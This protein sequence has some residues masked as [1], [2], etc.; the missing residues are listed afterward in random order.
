VICGLSGGV[1]SSVA[2][3]LDPEAIGDQLTCIFVDTGLMRAGEAER[4]VSLFRNHYNIPLIHADAREMFLGR[5]KGVSDPEQKRKISAPPSSM[6]STRKAQDRRRG[7]PRPRHPLS[8]RDRKRFGQR[9]TF[10]HH[11]EPPQ[12]RRL[13]DF[14]KLKLVEPLRDLFKDEVRAWAAN[15]ACRPPLSA[16]IPFPA[17]LAIRF[18]RDH[19]REAGNP[20]QG[21]HRLSGRNP[22]GRLYDKIWQAFAVLLPVRPWG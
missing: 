6:C 19:G 18:R 15:W 3:G 7:I 2:S 14:M 5:L 21:R 10:G 11:Q 9:R 12:C 17:R 1:D 4:G 8:R 13:P 22:Q 16:A 20:A